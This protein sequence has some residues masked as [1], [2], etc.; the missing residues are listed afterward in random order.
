MRSTVL[1]FAGIASGMVSLLAWP[2]GGSAIAP[3]VIPITPSQRHLAG[4]ETSEL[5]TSD[6]ELAGRLQ[7]AGRIEF[8]GH[9]PA[10]LLSPADGRITA[11][12]KHPGE[13]VAPGDRL[14]AISGPG[15]GSARQ[16]LRVA[17]TADEVARLRLSRDRSLLDA[18]A[19][20]RS[21]LEA[22]QAAARDA[23]VAL[24]TVRRRL[25]GGHFDASGDLLLHAPHAGRVLGPALAPG[26]AVSVGQSLAYVASRATGVHAAL[27]VPASIARTLRV[28]D[29]ALV[30]S[31]ACETAGRIH[32][33]GQDI[34]PAMQGVAVHID[35]A[36]ES[37]FLPG[38]AVSARLSRRSDSAGFPVPATAFVGLGERTYVFIEV[39]GGYRA[40][41]VDAEAAR[42]G[43]A[44]SA[45]LRAGARVVSRG[46]A[47]LKA[48]WLRAMGG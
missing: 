38:E 8:D 31:A 14:L 42:A 1:V 41:E 40:V 3:T 25:S 6:D 46:T 2:A 9:G 29:G 35:F 11:V 26:D 45:S 19:I 27:A 5:R 17:V 28:G 22:S 37:C 47:I 24:E 23:T 21:R 7:F 15:I 39:A 33:V 10:V 18:G 44:K 32:A 20:P 4:I 12:Y 34:D 43:F 48:V 16:E 36:A 30:R 13:P